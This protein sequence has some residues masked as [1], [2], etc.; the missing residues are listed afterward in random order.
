VY[1]DFYGN[2]CLISQNVVE[3]FLSSQNRTTIISIWHEE[4]CGESVSGK[5]LE[6]TE[7]DTMLGTEFSFSLKGFRDYL[8]QTKPIRF[9]TLDAHLLNC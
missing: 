5:T 8:Q 9:V 2:V 4:L 7:A 3:T 6:I 1:Y